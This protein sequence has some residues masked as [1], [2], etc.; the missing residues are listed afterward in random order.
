MITIIPI[1]ERAKYEKCMIC[2]CPHPK[3]FVPV[4][5]MNGVRTATLCNIC[6][7]KYEYIEEK[8]N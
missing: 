6:A 3:Y 4:R 8:E 1:E 7:L 2:Q 5:T